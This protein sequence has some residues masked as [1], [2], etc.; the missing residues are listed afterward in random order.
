[1]KYR[2]ISTDDHLQEAPDTWTSRMSAAK[3]GDKIPQLKPLDKER[4]AWFV[5]GEPNKR[6]GVALV[7]G[8]LPTVKVG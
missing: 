4:E 7:H 8:A 3:W 1:M 5:Y 6:L 2:V